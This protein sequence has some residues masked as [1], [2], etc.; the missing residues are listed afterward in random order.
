MR[1]GDAPE[2]WTVDA[3]P[4]AVPW[5]TYEG[6]D[7][8]AFDDPRLA[9]LKRDGVALRAIVGHRGAGAEDLELRVEWAA[10]AAVFSTWE[11]AVPLV[12]RLA[13]RR[14]GPAFA[15][16]A[17]LAYARD[18]APDLAPLFA[19][20]REGP[21][22]PLKAQ[23]P[24][25][26]SYPFPR[27]HEVGPTDLPI[28]QY[29]FTGK[30]QVRKAAPQRKRS[31]YIV[32]HGVTSEV[33][34]VLAEN[35]EL[36]NGVFKLSQWHI[37][38]DK[39]EKH[40]VDDLLVAPVCSRGSRKLAMTNFPSATV[41]TLATLTAFA[42][43]NGNARKP[44]FL[45]WPYCEVDMALAEAWRERLADR[46]S[47]PSKNA[48]DVACNRDR[49]LSNAVLRDDGFA[50]IA[51]R[52]EDSQQLLPEQVAAARAVIEKFLAAGSH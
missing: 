10:G 17:A 38:D 22:K 27:S 2:T 31:L 45:P 28:E 6:K 35:W 20:A 49:S 3:V 29:P 25:S 36:R 12:A 26:G 14:P 15:G 47:R 11:N 5:A 40:T 7:L 9:A 32:G 46:R 50:A 44:A 24:P 23:P 33:M 34:E 39:A 37:T 41:W 42:A 16:A 18:R 52:V 4:V 48:V 21:L 19:A 1:F 13:K 8:A 51:G 30:F 43:M